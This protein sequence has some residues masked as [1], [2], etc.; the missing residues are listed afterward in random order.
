MFSRLIFARG[1]RSSAARQANYSGQRFTS[2][3]FSVLSSNG[4]GQSS[5]PH[6]AWANV[7]LNAPHR[8]FS[9]HDDFSPKK[10]HNLDGSDESAILDL[11]E[12]HVKANR[13]MLY[14]KGSP[15]Q[16]MCGFSATVVQ[17]LKNQGVDFASVNVLDYPEVREGVK[18]YAQWPT[19]PQL[20]VDGEFVGGC[21]IV[22]DLH[23]SGE[24]KDLLKEA[25]GEEKQEGN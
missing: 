11:I 24:L 20:Y 18:K 8:Q 14:M 2:R 19:I 21:D 1:T 15:A 17:I 10:K 23:E 6:F 13:I 7:F 25:N 22:K 4:T 9:S 12:S 5:T 3:P 16:P